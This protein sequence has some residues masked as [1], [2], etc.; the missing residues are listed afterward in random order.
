VFVAVGVKVGVF[1][2]VGGRAQNT[3]AMLLVSS[4]VAPFCAKALPAKLALVV[5]VML[6]LA[7]I[8]PAN[9]EAVPTVAELP[10]RQNK[11]QPSPRP[12]LIKVTDEPDA[13]VSEDPILKTQ[14]ALGSP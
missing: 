14:T 3:G 2:A 10:T 13:V 6:E 11:L 8:F 4:V 9:V 12:P 7:R 1:V 5:M